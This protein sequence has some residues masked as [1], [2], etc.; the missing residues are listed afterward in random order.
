[1]KQQK[2]L[3]RF[4]V[5]LLYRSPVGLLLFLAAC[6]GG[7][8]SPG[9]S[10]SITVPIDPGVQPVQ[11][12]LP[13]EEGNPRP[14]GRMVGP[15][16]VAM[17]F[18]LGELLVGTN[19]SGKLNAFLGRWGGTVLETVQ[20][21]GGQPALHRVSLDPSSA[22]VNQLLAEAVTGVPE[23]NASF[24]TSSE[25]ASKL[26]A[27]ALWEIKKN[28]FT[29]MPNFLMPNGAISDGQLTEAS[30]GDSGYSPNPFNWPYMNQGS[31]QDIGVGAAWQ[32]LD[33][34]GKLGNKINIMVIDG[35][36]YPNP[37]MPT[38]LTVNK[39]NVSNP[40][41]CSGGNPCP[42]HGTMVATA[43]L[44]QLNNNY[45]AAGPAGPI[46]ELTAVHMGS[47]FFGKI[48]SFAD[49]LNN[50]LFTNVKVINISMGFELDS[51]WDTVTNLLCFGLCPTPSEVASG[52]TA[53]I[54]ASGR[55]I[56]ASA[57]NEGKDIDLGGGKEDS[58]YIPC[59]LSGVICVGGMAHN[60]A[61][62][63]NGSNFGSKTTGG[64]VDI[65]GPFST[66]VGPDPDNLQ[67]VARLK[68]GT[69]FASP[70]VAG[71]AALIW[72]AKPSL[73]APQVEQILMENAHVGGVGV[74]GKQYRVNAYKAVGAVLAGSPP[75]I[76]LSAPPSGQLNREVYI[77][78]TATDPE[79]GAANCP[80]TVCLITWEPAP[81]T[82]FF[83]TDNRMVAV[84][85]FNT[86]GPQ[87][88]KATVKD[89]G[90]ASASASTTVTVQNSVPTVNI[91]Q[92]TD[93]GSFFQ[94][95]TVQL[96]GS[97]FDLNE[98]PDPGP[99]PLICV[100]R[101]SN[102][103]D[104]GFPKLGCDSTAIFSSQGPRT[105][106][107]T[108]TDPQGATTSASVSIT[109]TPPP[110]N[111]PPVITLGA[112]PPINYRQGYDWD[113]F[114]AV[115]ASATDP[116]NNNPISFTWR[117]TSFAAGG[118]TNNV[119][120]SNLTIAGPSTTANLN[121]K[122]STTPSLFVTSCNT[123]ASLEGQVVRITLTATDSLGNS[124]SKNLP[125]VRIYRCT[126]YLS[127]P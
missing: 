68:N 38:A 86:A 5:W 75:S 24:R 89:P 126:V 80:Y 111:L 71:V 19:D 58:T 97:A 78:A 26:L 12:T 83:T 21:M 82:F 39:P 93:G 9:P 106:T 22:Q 63:A 81:T 59:E 95:S 116:E 73:T 23:A 117:A 32:A 100:W 1:M 57:G 20:P 4:L 55:L 76:T 88:I 34:A 10:G 45:G 29:L 87:T 103:S 98:G 127:R 99:G 60:S 107:M 54:A 72:A 64:T 114:F 40:A 65:Y 30:S 41:K 51:A 48:K 122:P 14:V 15:N 94:G 56:F 110:T 84:Y 112:P 43:A 53:A 49:I 101:S 47:G 90:G 28:G 52:V 108:A 123:Q 62:K 120:A 118:G 3:G 67:N 91:A 105:I 66:W 61:A 27:V 2:G 74:S 85:R 35:G 121:W 70:F 102:P 119:F 36:F 79:Y 69:S 109:I 25:A 124:S 6:G 16:G 104:S 92:P 37:D 113:K 50:L 96:L 11:D 7:G 115:S 77:T 17:D 33:K 46:A 13:D 42:W 8:N 31:A 44:G 18:V 125:D